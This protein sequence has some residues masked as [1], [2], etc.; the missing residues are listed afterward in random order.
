MIQFV[1]YQTKLKDNKLTFEFCSSYDEY[2]EAM[3]VANTCP[4]TIVIPFDDDDD[5]DDPETYFIDYKE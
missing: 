1:V 5:D 2:D 4:N 3:K